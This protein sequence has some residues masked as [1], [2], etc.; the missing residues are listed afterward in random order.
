MTTPNAATAAVTEL[1]A[2]H[3]RNAKDALV[4]LIAKATRELAI[5]EAGQFQRTDWIEQPAKAYHEAITAMV[6]TSEALSITM[7]YIESDDDRKFAQSKA[8]D[9][10]MQS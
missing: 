8:S 7:H 10:E 4:E 1:F 6:A 2:R 3:Q 5:H 9:G